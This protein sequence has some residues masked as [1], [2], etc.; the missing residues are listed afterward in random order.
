MLESLSNLFCLGFWQEYGQ[1]WQLTIQGEVPLHLF[2]VFNIMLLAG[3]I[4]ISSPMWVGY[5][6]WRI[7]RN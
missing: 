1:F 3:L 5:L 6:L 7:G 4:I 2:V